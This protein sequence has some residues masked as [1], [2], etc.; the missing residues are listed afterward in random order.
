MCKVSNTYS[1][2]LKPP[3]NIDLQLFLQEVGKYLAYVS[4]Y[5]L[6]RVVSGTHEA[7]TLVSYKHFHFSPC[8]T[9]HIRVADL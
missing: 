6:R 8:P 3:V 2:R 5:R 1:A 4:N 7:I 9:V